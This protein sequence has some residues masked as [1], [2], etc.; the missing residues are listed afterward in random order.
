MRLRCLLLVLA[1]VSVSAQEADRNASHKEIY[2]LTTVPSLSLSG[3]MRQVKLQVSF[4]YLLNRRGLESNT[5]FYS[6]GMWIGYTMKA[7]WAFGDRSSPFDEI[8][9]NP[10][11]WWEFVD[12]NTKEP[13]YRVGIEHESNGEAGEKSRSWNKLYAQRVDADTGEEGPWLDASWTRRLDVKFWWAFQVSGRNHDIAKY[14]GIVDH[15][16]LRLGY[17]AL[18]E[19]S[20]SND[21]RDVPYGYR[22]AL[23]TRGFPLPFDQGGK[24]GFLRVDA[25]SRLKNVYLHGQFVRGYGEFMNKYKKFEPGKLRIGGMLKPS[26]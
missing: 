24:H 18:I 26:L 19:L 4:K 5:E 3:L 11:I 9:H 21:R 16:S 2:F 7:D 1:A 6:Q 12:S 14:I 15:G 25:N 23:R 10:E 20:E 8:I 13:V 17:D 22:L